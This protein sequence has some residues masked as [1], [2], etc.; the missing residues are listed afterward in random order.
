MYEYSWEEAKRYHD[1]QRWKL[2]FEENC[3]CA[4][5]IEEIIDAN[6][7][8]M[9]LNGKC[10][11]PIIEEFG[12]DRMMWV[13]AATLKEKSHD[14]RFSDSNKKWAET[15]YIPK[16]KARTEYSVK[17]HPAVMDGFINLAH[18]EWA[19]LKLFDNQ[20]CLSESAEQLDYTNKVVV[21][22]PYRMKDE[23]KTPDDQLFYA[24][25]GFGCSPNSRGRKVFGTY[26]KDGESCTQVREDILGI[27]KDEY[28]PD[29]AKEKLQ[30][31]C[32]PQPEQ[33]AG[34][35]MQ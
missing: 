3:R 34:I 14:G 21:I 9:H 13:L 20:H 30:E 31:L 5:F 11:K 22:N 15:F 26:L 28:L 17:S 8:G 4:T 6:F 10:V 35:T 12:F 2:S 32:P 27:L 1:E 24:T 25:G 29:W 33:G 23:Y 19:E 7:D 16:E 18:K